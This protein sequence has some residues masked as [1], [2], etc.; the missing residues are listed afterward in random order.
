[1]CIKH[2]FQEQMML[3]NKEMMAWTIFRQRGV[4]LIELIMFIVIISSALIGIL[5]V[6]NITT[7]HS[8]DPLVH[9]QAI[10]VAE[11][12]LEE[13]E[14]QDF[15]A[16]AAHVAVNAGNR[17]SSLATGYHIIS[18]YNGF[19]MA[20]ITRPDGTAIT[21]LSSYI[22]DVSVQNRALGTIPAAG[23]VLITVTV[24]DPSGN[25]IQIDGYRTAY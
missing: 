4:S 8:A 5:S 23:A 12:L 10:A 22:A 20:G 18:D 9:K 24:T 13:I 15:T 1:M 2:L 17:S 21:G 25:P 16:A 19:H 7:A 6:M 14:L 3:A 11:S